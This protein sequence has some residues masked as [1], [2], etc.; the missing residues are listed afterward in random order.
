MPVLNAICLKFRSNIDV[1]MSPQCFTA[2]NLPQFTNTLESNAPAEIT[3]VPASILVSRGKEKA[4]V[5]LR[6]NMHHFKV[7]KRSLD[8][9]AKDNVVEQD[10]GQLQRV[11]VISRE[12]AKDEH[13]ER[14]LGALTE[15]Y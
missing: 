10:A 7:S 2:K 6:I 14:I 9:I 5:L 4:I 12:R 3:V 11:Q 15:A 1:I 13:E 8:E